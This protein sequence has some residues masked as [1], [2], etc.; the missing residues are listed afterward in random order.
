MLKLVKPIIT[1]IVSFSVFLLFIVSYLAWPFV[2]GYVDTTGRVKL[3]AQLGTQYLNSFSESL[4]TVYDPP[5]LLFLDSNGNCKTK[6]EIKEVVGDGFKEGLILLNDRGRIG[7]SDFLGRKVGPQH[8]LEARSFSGG[9]A[10]ARF[11]NGLWGFIDKRG[12][13]RIEPQFE[14]VLDFSEGL[15]AVLDPKTKLIGF[16]TKTGDFHLTPKYT[17]AMPF[18]E[19]V[20]LTVEKGQSFECFINQSG[21]V[22]LDVSMQPC[23]RR[24]IERIGE[25]RASVLDYE[26][27][28][29]LQEVSKWKCRPKL[30]APGYEKMIV[31]SP[32]NSNFVDGVA[33]VT[34][35]DRFGYVDKGGKQIT[36]TP[37]KAISDFNCHHA[38]FVDSGK[39]G[40]IDAQGHVICK[41]KYE[42]IKPFS[43]NYA[44][45]KVGKKWVLMDSD[46]HLHDKCSGYSLDP[47]RNGLCRFGEQF[48][49]DF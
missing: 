40:V 21:K 31:N 3:W 4:T 5:Y 41:A 37:F 43:E 28:H 42:S 24:Q 25:L 8:L 30:V 23:V 33:Q 47:P 49:W 45:A 12:N 10:A 29:E 16:I 17:F 14:K 7:F 32:Y 1:G 48:F 44:T 27:M 6:T 26:S 22:M 2:T 39:L 13:W 46:G 19:G 36:L 34:V 35:N 9:L 18:S 38:L 11:G 15:S 20:A